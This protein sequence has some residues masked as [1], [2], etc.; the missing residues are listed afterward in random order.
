[1]GWRG[2]VFC[3]REEL[4]HGFGVPFHEF[5]QRQ[6]ILLDQSI[7]M[8]Y[9][10]HLEITSTVGALSFPQGHPAIIL[11]YSRECVE[12]DKFYEVRGS[13]LLLCAASTL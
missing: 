9:G 5:V 6:L 4:L 7:D 11:R 8:V 3:V 13:K 2:S 10:R 12:K 1:M